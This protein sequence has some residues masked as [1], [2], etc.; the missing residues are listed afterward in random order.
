[1]WECN[2]V[3]FP[4]MSLILDIGK[5]KLLHSPTVQLYKF[6]LMTQFPRLS[7]EFNIANS[8]VSRFVFPFN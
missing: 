7:I 8:K 6:F 3:A 5:S 4:Q 1:M 2:T